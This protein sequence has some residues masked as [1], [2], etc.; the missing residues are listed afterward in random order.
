M[1]ST[2]IP[3]II[4]TTAKDYDR[5]TRNLGDFFRLLPV[6]EVI[7][8][9]PA[10]LEPL[11]LRDAKTFENDGPVRYIN[12]ND[13]ISF[14]ILTQ[15]MREHLKAGGFAMS[16]DSK[17]GWY[18][19]QFLKMSFSDICED[20]YYMSWDADTIP[21]RETEMFDPQGRPYFD[22]KT[23]Y[24]QSYFRTIKKVWGYDK[25]IEPSFIS[26]HMIFKTS[27][28]KELIAETE[29]LDIKGEKYYEKIFFS[30]PYDKDLMRGF[31]EFETYGT[32]VLN[33]HPDFYA[34]RDWHSMRITGAFT[35]PED[36]TDEDKA[37][38]ASD[39]DAATFESYHVFSPELAEFFRDPRYRSRI[40]ARQ[41]YQIVLESGFFGDMESGGLKSSDG[42]LFAV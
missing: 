2:R 8:I 31:S 24:L 22:V 11:V 39:Y 13:L 21:L 42:D 17:P 41:F 26:E 34:L 7:F 25:A 3:L 14:D 37:W 23:E 6:K 35:K 9:G 38:L 36:L 12:E 10:G 29:A 20:E 19:Q 5:I 40:S 33:N 18:Y 16:A 4:P 1:F 15:V 27:F 28:M 30:L 32:W